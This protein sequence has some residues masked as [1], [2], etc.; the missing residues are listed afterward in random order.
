MADTPTIHFPLNFKELSPNEVIQEG[1]MLL[2]S[3]STGWKLAVKCVG[4]QYKNN[5][6]LKPQTIVARKV[7]SAQWQPQIRSLY[8]KGAG[9]TRDR[10]L[11]TDAIRRKFFPGY[12]YGNNSGQDF[13]ILVNYSGRNQCDFYCGPHSRESCFR[14][15][16]I[17]SFD[18]FVFY[19]T[20]PEEK[21]RKLELNLNIDLVERPL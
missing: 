2:A 9:E 8:V 3:G 4:A 5:N 6:I 12:C 13:Y 14:G 21:K 17:I 11:K 16:E 10:V 19:F 15:C 20:S 1:D 18:E 7:V